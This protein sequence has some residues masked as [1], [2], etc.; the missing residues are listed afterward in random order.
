MKAQR[1]ARGNARRDGASPAVRE[2]TREQLLRLIDARSRA[3]LGVS[4]E[5]FM[6]LYKE[7]RLEHS[8]AEAPVIVLA[9][10]LAAS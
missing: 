8:P 9:D 3:L 6:C 4:G 5:E 2:L 10:L 7:G 1:R